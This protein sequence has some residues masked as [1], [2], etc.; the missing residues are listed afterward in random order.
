MP[1]F[2]QAVMEA[3]GVEPFRWESWIVLASGEEFRDPAPA[4]PLHPVAVEAGTRRERRN[5]QYEIPM[6]PKG[7]CQLWN[8]MEAKGYSVE[9]RVDEHGR[10][11]R[12]TKPAGDIHDEMHVSFGYGY[13]GGMRE[14]ALVEAAAAMLE[15]KKGN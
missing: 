2:Y 3:A 7:F 9:F 10:F 5:L 1:D 11:C 15:V 8:A 14:T 13:S 12:I 4:V 6:L